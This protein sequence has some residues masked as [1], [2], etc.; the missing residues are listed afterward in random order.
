MKTS[1]IK[2]ALAATALLTIASALSVTAATFTVTNTNDTGPGSLRQA[3][4]DANA[5]TTAD[6]IVFDPGLFGT[7]Q[8]ITL[9]TEIQISNNFNTVDTLTITGPGSNLLTVSGN[10]V[11]RIFQTIQEDTA[12]ISGMT[13]TNGL[14]DNGGALLNGGVTTLTDMIFRQNTAFNGGAILNAANGPN[15]GVLN[16]SRCEFRD[17]TTTGTNINGNGGSAIASFGTLTVTD[18]IITGGMTRGGGGAL[19]IGGGVVDITSTT[20]SNNTSGGVGNSDGGGGIYT[21]SEM[22]LTNC[23]ISGNTA[24]EDTDGGGIYNERGL[25]LINT[26]VT[27]NTAARHGGG[28]YDGGGNND[29]SPIYFTIITNSTISHNVANTGG[30]TQVRGGGVYAEG[31]PALTITGSTIHDN[32]IGSGEGGGIWSASTTRIDRSTISR[33]TAREFGGV[34]LVEI[35]HDSVVTNSTIANN[36]AT[37][38]NGGGG[39]GKDQCGLGCTEVSI[40]NTIISGN[41]NG[42]LRSGDLADGDSNDVAIRSLGYNLIHSLTLNA[43][44]EASS[45]D[46][47]LGT[48]PDFEELRDNG[49][50]TLTHAPKPGSP[51]IDKGRRLSDAIID[52]RGVPRPSDNPAL[53]NAQGGDGSDI[54]AFE[55][56]ESIGVAKET[57]GNISTRLPVL[58]GDN[59]PI[60]GIIVAGSVPKRVIIR[61]LGPSLAAAGVNGAL[62]NPTLQL[63]QGETLIAEN[64]NWREDQEKAISQTGVAP[65]DNREAAIVRTL[66]PGNYTAI[67][68]GKD[69]TTGIGLVEAYDLDQR[70]NSKL[71]NISTRGVVGSGDD[72]L[73]GGFIVGPTTRVVVRAIGPSL[74]NA[75]IQG[76]L[77]DPILELVNANGQVIR[78]NDNWQG[79][80]KAEIKATG[81][82][83]S[84]ERESALLATLTAGSY[85]A[86]VRG[87]TDGSGIGLVEVYNLQ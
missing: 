76:S 34:R 66:E 39:L 32:R 5:A 78:A 85:T 17:N 81:L 68:R 20:I 80:Q 70:P 50:G 24:G 3:V 16:I 26:I 33:N 58:T 75:G 56:G 69:N 84:D 36:T 11:T 51:V 25:T 29:G 23:I 21:N 40:G 30:S 12:S 72:V 79:I 46:L 45:T 7:P 87:A 19:R 35:F 62:A 49:G 13:L 60:G 63:F 27:N 9:A 73:I 77:Q 8:T 65:S 55:I 15:S 10:N 47:P 44:Y 52:Q 57:L 6:T 74:A 38:Q 48:D 42:D 1:S 14:G 71:V 67:V 83:P 28:I 22:T 2:H 43:L 37:L 86:V 18:S 82:Q 41:T 31:G 59:V 61:A 54:G 4:L 53:A 64:D